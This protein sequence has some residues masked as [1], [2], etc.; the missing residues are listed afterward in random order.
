[1]LHSAKELHPRFVFRQPCAKAACSWCP[2]A[3]VEWNAWCKT[4]ECSSSPAGWSLLADDGHAHPQLCWTSCQPTLWVSNSVRA[5]SS[6][7]SNQLRLC[8]RQRCVCCVNALWFLF[9]IMK[10]RSPMHRAS[11]WKV[12]P[13]EFRRRPT[14]LEIERQ[15]ITPCRSPRTV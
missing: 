8:G 12:L 14:G 13:G 15:T 1:M 6:Q 4:R 5:C 9:G 11:R 3:A 10:P 2:A 7:T